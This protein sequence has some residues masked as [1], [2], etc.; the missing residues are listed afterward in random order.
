ME[1]KAA[2]ILL[3]DQLFDLISHRTRESLAEKV[4][5]WT[6][7]S[8]SLDCDCFCLL[9]RQLLGERATRRQLE[10]M[11]MS[12]EPK[13]G[14]L[15]FGS[16]VS[17]ARHEAI[18]T[19]QQKLTLRKGNSFGNPELARFEKQYRRKTDQH[20]RAHA[21]VIVGERED[22]HK[23]HLD[24]IVQ[25]HRMERER[26]RLRTN[27]TKSVYEKLRL[28]QSPSRSASRTLGPL[29]RLT[30]SLST[31]SSYGSLVL[32][33]PHH[34]TPATTTR[35]PFI[36]T[37]ASAASLPALQ[38]FPRRAAAHDSEHVSERGIH[39]PLIGNLPRGQVQEWAEQGMYLSPPA[40]QVQCAV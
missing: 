7:Q 30:P 12:L 8:T 5:E 36:S 22:E 32:P 37:S 40:G 11:F 33:R 34:L 28:P 6:G 20:V 14:L 23:R 31:S 18:F 4:H 16:L 35:L 19:S 26:M 10:A 3:R 21:R 29:G 27:A 17:R 1:V 13:E 39:T 25:H 9:A 2:L 15:D 24:G 38:L